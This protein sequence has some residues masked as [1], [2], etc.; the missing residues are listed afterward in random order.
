[1]LAIF[2]Q[3][4][5]SSFLRTPGINAFS[6]GS[7]GADRV[8]YNRNCQYAGAITHSGASGNAFVGCSGTS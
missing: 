2:H 7:P 8:I 4:C 3:L 1:M 6:L 5:F